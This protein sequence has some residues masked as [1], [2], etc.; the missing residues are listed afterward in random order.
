MDSRVRGNDGNG[1]VGGNP[2]DLPGRKWIPAFGGMTAMETHSLLAFGGATRRTLH[3]F[4]LS[5]S[6]TTFFGA[7]VRRIRS[8]IDLISAI[9]LVSTLCLTVSRCAGCIEK[10]RKPRPSN[11]L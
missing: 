7:S 9:S 8:T 6:A 4:N 2:K 1:N 5:S 10:L 11:S 3:A